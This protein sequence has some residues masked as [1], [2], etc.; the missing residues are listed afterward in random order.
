MLR[1]GIPFRIP[2]P[3][4]G[5]GAARAL[6]GIM[7]GAHRAV[8][9]VVLGLSVQYPQVGA[10]EHDAGHATDEHQYAKHDVIASEDELHPEESQRHEGGGDEAPEEVRPTNFL[11][12]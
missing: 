7:R 9:P 1:A 8:K 11:H 10:E 12:V 2:A 4:V 3:C 6:P 5:A